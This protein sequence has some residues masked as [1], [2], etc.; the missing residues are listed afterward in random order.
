MLQAMKKTTD[1]VGS[2]E[3][4]VWHRSLTRD[5]TEEEFMN[6]IKASQDHIKF[7]DLPN[8]RQLCRLTK[9]H[10]SHELFAIE[11]QEKMLSGEE[12][13]SRIA[14]MRKNLGI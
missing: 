9:S 4:K 6:G 8:F 10:K 12:L 7:L 13:R 14:D 1:P 11:K 5:F 3:M 2:T